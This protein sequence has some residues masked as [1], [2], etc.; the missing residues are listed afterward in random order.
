MTPLF[1]GLAIIATSVALWFLSL[2]LLGL[3]ARVMYLGVMTGWR[4][5]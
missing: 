3:I 1:R 2:V 4:L 5:L